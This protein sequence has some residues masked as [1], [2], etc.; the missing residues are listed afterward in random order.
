MATLVFS[1]LGTALG[2]PLGGA[3]GALAGRQL[4]SA[5]LGPSARNGPRLREL[6]V[7]L[8]SYGTAIPRI[9]GRMRVAG[10]I[11]W[12]TELQE[13]SELRGTGKGQPA[14]TAYGYTANL[15][16]ALS[17]RP[18][19]GVGRIWADGKLLRGAAGD[20]KTGGQL[21]VYLGSE[22]QPPD[23]LIAASEGE[24][25]CPAF[26]GLAY[27]VFDALDLTDFGN[28][29]PALTFEVVADAQVTMRAI[30]GDTLPDVAVPHEMP[31]L[32]GFAV[33]DN[34]G[35]SL[36]ALAPAVPISL[37]AAGDTIVVRLVDDPAA[38]A[39]LDEPAIA[40]EDD[41]FGG[42]TGISRRRMSP[43][44]QPPSVLRFFD[45][46][47]DFQPATQ[48]ASGRARL[49]QPDQVEVPAALDVG[50]ARTLVEQ[51]AQ[52][53]DRAQERIAWR[54]AT[55]DTAV[56]PGTLVR[57]PGRRGTWRVESW[58]WREAGVELDLV[59][60][61]TGMAPPALRPVLPSFPAPIDLSPAA[62]RIVACELPWD[63]AA[64]AP[65]RTRVAAAVSADGANW[66][67]AA[68]YADRGDGQL[69]P[70]GPASR[71]R[72]VVG[73][74]VAA[75]GRASHLLIDRGGT[76]TV[77]LAAPDFALGSA[78]LAELA[79]GANL[80]L[81]GDELIQFA[82]AEALGPAR[83]RLSGLL[84]GQGGT[85]TAIAGHR[86]GEDFALLDAKLSMVD[87]SA[88]GTLA[89]A[90]IIALGRGDAAP[91]TAP[92]H[93]AGIALRP[94]SPVHAR[95][96]SLPSG[97]LRLAWTRRARGGWSWRDGVDVPLAEES[98]RY[99]VTYEEAGTTLRAWTIATNALTLT[100]TER[101]E[102][103]EL[104]AAGVFMVRQQGTHGLS[105]PLRLT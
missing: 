13:H 26:R 3:I 92:V 94:L 27:V 33:E 38:A 88:I 81:V 55:L 24:A 91:V 78:S 22:D 66:S 45:V 57:L 37:D 9:H 90:A 102:L 68:L 43:D 12:A 32:A 63:A 28:R 80:A 11:I 95:V 36:A 15:A 47:R 25:R 50:T 79:N 19:T 31:G 44:P 64:G 59:R 70:L 51:M 103:A 77:L 8:S 58:E 34:L 29:I 75:L 10:A 96:T 99:L 16:V 5:L 61:P 2:G 53:R 14:L 40:V 42:A 48:H 82:K 72:A 20:L 93:L 35:A 67:G 69:W 100:P 74:T 56:A 60:V 46:D 84:R 41:A 4:D 98:E 105:L 23:P 39:T 6:E 18:I 21:R 65:D 7:S 71:G 49:G 76:L 17:S 62:T 73:T 97:D 89:G 1:T 101:Q 86:A 83:W 87:A 85:E 30:L 104:S 54:T 52:R